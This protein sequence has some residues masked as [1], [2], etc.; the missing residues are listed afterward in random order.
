MTLTWILYIKVSTNNCIADTL[1]NDITDHC[2]NVVFTTMPKSHTSDPKYITYRAFTD[3]NL[4][5]FNEELNSIDWSPIY[6]T[7]NP[8]EAYDSFI[9]LHKDALDKT[10]PLKTKFN[11]LKHAKQSWMTKGIL[12]SIKQKT[13]L[14]KAKIHAKVNKIYYKPQE[15]ITYIEMH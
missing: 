7:Q 12:N 15:I 3:R 1:F 4:N 5:L 14:Y 6:N 8:N 2:I 9:K 11:K 13:K 10:I